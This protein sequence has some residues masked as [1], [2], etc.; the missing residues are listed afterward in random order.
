[1]KCWLTSVF[2]FRVLSE[3]V[4]GEALV[5]GVECIRS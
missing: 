5:M 4:E 2:A 1:M 3:A